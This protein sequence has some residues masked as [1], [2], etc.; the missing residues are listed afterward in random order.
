MALFKR[1][2]FD[3]WRRRPFSAHLSGSWGE[4]LNAALIFACALWLW[5]GQARMALPLQLALWLGV[6]VAVAV[7]VRARWAQLFGPVFLYDLIRTT[8]RGQY[9]SQRC[10][11]AFLLLILLFLVYIAFFGNRLSDLGDLIVGTYLP[12]SEVT[13]FADA[14]FNSFMCLQYVMILLLTPVAAAGAIAEEKERRTLDYLLTTQLDDREIV[15]GKLGARL[16]SLALFVLTGLPILGLLPF[17]GGVDPNLVMAGYAATGLTMLSVGSLSILNSAYA[18]KS[19]TAVFLT[20]FQV[21]VYLVFTS[22]CCLPFAFIGGSFNPLNW[23]AAGNIIVAVVRLVAPS[24]LKLSLLDDLPEVLRD[25]A[26]FHIAAAVV[27]LVYAKMY[28]R[29]WNRPPVSLLV[30]EARPMLVRMPESPF[31]AVEIERWEP[32]IKPNMG[33]DPILWKELYAEPGLGLGGAGHAIGVIPVTLVVFVFAYFLLALLLMAIVSATNRGTVAEAM[34]LLVRV[35]GTT[36][37]CFLILGV[38][39]RA[40]GSFSGERDRQTLDGLLTTD[41]TDEEIVRGKWFGTLL[42]VRQGCCA[43][44]GIWVLGFVTGGLNFLAIPALAT[45]WFLLAACMANL[46]MLF[47]LRSRSTLRATVGTML[48]VILL[49]LAPWVA[50]LW[51]ESFIALFGLKDGWGWLLEFDAYALTP[52]LALVV[53]AR[54]GGEPGPQAMVTGHTLT[55]ASLGLAGYGVLALLFGRLIINGF[56]QAVSRMP[57]GKSRPIRQSPRQQTEHGASPHPVCD[58]QAG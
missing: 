45:G 30:Q 26:I 44:A 53:L 49:S 55:V 51:A 3:S 1:T 15:L 33:T 38:A 17:L 10:I 42:S 57:L 46:G 40:A 48:S 29:A 32:K 20:Y 34:N 24:P 41:L 4:Y 5:L 12:M 58:G 35:M 21:L 56:G 23:G 50:W 11:Y 37:A 6:L 43:L 19:R 14:F 25:F 47:S 28:L 27:C 22:M 2:W 9:F 18:R 31:D 16:A 39:L 52:P 7:L 36:L 8:R 13:K 54:H